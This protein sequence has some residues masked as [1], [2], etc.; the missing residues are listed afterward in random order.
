VVGAGV[1]GVAAVAAQ[2]LHRAA[3]DVPL[4]SAAKAAPDGEGYR[5]TPHVLRYYETTKA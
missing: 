4:A 5:L 1:A 2:A 3:V